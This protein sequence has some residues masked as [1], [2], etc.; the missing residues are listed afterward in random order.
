MTKATIY[1]APK[2]PHTKNLRAFL[3][4]QSLEIEEKCVLTSPELFE[5]VKQVSGQLGI[6]VAVIDGEAFVGFDRRVERRLKR[7]LGV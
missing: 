3:D 2:C 6:P 7:K 4:E 5:E 1:T